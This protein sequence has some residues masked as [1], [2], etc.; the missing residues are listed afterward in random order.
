MKV[1]ASYY[2]SVHNYVVNNN[3]QV[4]CCVIKEMTHMPHSNSTC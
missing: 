2:L 1:L 3:V 4:R